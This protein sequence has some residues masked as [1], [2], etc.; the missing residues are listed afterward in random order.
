[1]SKHSVKQSVLERKATRV[2][3]VDPKTSGSQQDLDEEWARF[4]NEKKSL[5]VER[6]A[7]LAERANLDNKDKRLNGMFSELDDRESKLKRKM[8]HLEDQKEQWLR[9]ATD[10][11]RRETVIE[12]WQKNHAAREK[13]L[14]D[15]ADE[16]EKRFN[17]LLEREIVV[18]EAEQALKTKESDFQMKEQRSEQYFAKVEATEKSYSLR[19]E[20]LTNLEGEL[21][22]REGEIEIRE[23]EMASR[24]RELESWDLSVKEREK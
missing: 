13:R 24:R 21:R 17:T 19:E 9:S 12:D 3:N 8:E 1:M 18:T 11:F 6:A 10:L 16:Q 14:K 2:A 7:M 22:K 20:N 5:S 15:L 23:R 4:N